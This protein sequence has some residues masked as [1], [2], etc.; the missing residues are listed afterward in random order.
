MY[1]RFGKDDVDCRL[2]RADGDK[3]LVL[4]RGER[5]LPELKPCKDGSEVLPG[6][7]L[8]AG[9]EARAI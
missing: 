3:A 7:R 8:T 9:L 6:D 2:P 5:D 1:S 4:S